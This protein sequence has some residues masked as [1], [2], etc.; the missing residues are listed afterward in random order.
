MCDW[1]YGKMYAVHM[2]PDGSAYKA[3][4]EEFVTGTPLPLTDVVINPKDGAMY[5]TIG[6]RKT[7]SGLYRVSY[8][9]K[10]EEKPLLRSGSG[11]DPIATRRY[12]ESLHVKKDPAA[13]EQI[14]KGLYSKDRFI[15]NAARV[16]LEF[17]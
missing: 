4:A 2:K 16:A 14:W 9:G 17:L 6:G 12:F 8:V 15:Q 5:F 3:E 1:S 13:L 7:K 10:D 11:P